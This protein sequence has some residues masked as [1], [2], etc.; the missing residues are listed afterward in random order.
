MTQPPNPAATPRL[1][2]TVLILRDDPFE[3]L[4]V[5]RHADAHFGSVHV[6]PGGVVDAHDAADDWLDHVDGAEGLDVEERARRI[7]ACRETFEEAGLLLAAGEASEATDPSAS[8]IEAVRGSGARLALGALYPFG[9][10]ITPETAAKRFD[11]HF[12]LCRA[13]EGQTAVCDGR[14]TVSLEWVPPAVMLTGPE[15]QAGEIMFPTL[16]N[17]KR[18]A[19]SDNSEDAIARAKTRPIVTVIPRVER[20]PEG[21]RIHIPFDAGYGVT[22]SPP[23]VR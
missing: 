19:E 10:W 23:Y 16:M 17:L 3:V 5:R 13:P 6:F 2:A 14:E 12:Y 8:F 15:A 21:R 1:A 20:T 9:H 22:Q 18:L 4:M 7:A 11:T